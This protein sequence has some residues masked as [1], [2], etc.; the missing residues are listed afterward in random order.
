L[1]YKDG[2][3]AEGLHRE[4]HE[5][6]QPRSEETYKDGKREGLLRSWY[7]NGQLKGEETYK[8]D[9]PVNP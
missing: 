5:N 9:K 2:K 4:W 1:A 7:E 6:G 8:D 3:P